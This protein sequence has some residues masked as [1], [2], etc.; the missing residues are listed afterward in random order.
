MMSVLLVD[1]ARVEGSEVYAWA[2]RGDKPDFITS[3]MPALVAG[4]H[5]LIQRQKN[6]DGIG[7]RACPSS[8]IIDA[9]VG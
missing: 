1:P 5:A 9:Q 4:I 8:A 7:T 2:R 3:V 6:V